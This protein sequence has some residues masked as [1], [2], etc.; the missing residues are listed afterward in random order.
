M[1]H[2][3]ATVAITIIAV[4]GRPALAQDI[5]LPGPSVIFQH[6]RLEV[7]K[8]H[9]FLQQHDGT[10]FLYLGDTAWELF[11]RLSREDAE[12]YLEMR[13][14][15]GFTVI[16]TVVLAEFDGLTVPNAYGDRPLIDNNPATPNEAYFA[17]VDWIVRKAA[18]KGLVV[19][20]LPTWGDKVVLEKWGKGPVIFPVDHPE[21]A[22]AWGQ[23]LGARYRSAPNIIWILGG[24]R[25]AGG[26]E[27]VWNAMADGLAVGDGGAHLKTYHPGGRH[28]SAEW[29]QD[30]PWL[31]FNMLQSGH[32]DPNFANDR[33][34]D[35]DYA[36]TP[37]KPVLDGE[38][39][40]ENHPIN[41]DPTKGWFNAADVRQALYWS[42]FAGGMGVTYG[43]HDVWQFHTPTSDPIS[44]SRNYWY[45]VLN[46]PGAWDVIHLRRLLL[47]RPFFERV[48]DQEMIVS[49][50]TEDAAHPRATRG[51]GY[52]FVY[53]PTGAPVT[54]RLGRISGPEVQAWWFNPR[55]GQTSS[56]NRFT[57]ISTRTFTPPAPHGVG[58]DWVLVL[59]DLDREFKP[60]GYRVDDALKVLKKSARP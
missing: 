52:A 30:A 13:R 2:L 3:L 18:E 42:V 33:M 60:P 49:G 39:R 35:S 46:L 53:L 9:R 6:G 5:P 47:S 27:P 14:Q 37:V 29:F 10:P 32:S 54:L 1:R 4:G 17:H 43:C 36:R 45:D 58:Y 26:F 11:H 40:Y 7:S 20:M 22:R 15:Q 50:A 48:P 55:T 38:P 41:W 59:D 16:Q 34:M 12:R 51:H 44:S 24:D 25:T 21:I 8:N 19:G 56:L 31:D 23:F 28:S 57:N